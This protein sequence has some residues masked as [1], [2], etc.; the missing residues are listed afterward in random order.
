MFIQP[1]SDEHWHG[2]HPSFTAIRNTHR[3]C[4]MAASSVDSHKAMALTQPRLRT[5]PRS[6]KAA[7]A[8]TVRSDERRCQ[9]QHPV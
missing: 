5:W 4:S 3:V 1:S 9:R 2:L 7:R 8:A 6:P